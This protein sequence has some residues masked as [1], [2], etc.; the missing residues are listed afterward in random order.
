MP[1]DNNPKLPQLTL[2]WWMDGVTLPTAPEPQE[3]A[4]L[5]NGMQSFWQRVRGWFI[6]P[7]VQQDPLTCSLDM[8]N[9]KAWEC[10]ITRFRDEPLWLYR[11]R[12]AY[13]FINA[14]DAGSTQGFFKIMSRLGLRVV[15]IKERQE[16]LDW[17]RVSIEIDDTEI[18]TNQA[19]LAELIQSYGRTCRRY[20]H[21][22]SRV[23]VNSVAITEAC[24]DFQT[25]TITT[26]SSSEFAHYGSIAVPATEC[27]ND[28]QHLYV[29]RA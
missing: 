14:K 18:A 24:Q 12:V 29:R 22:S 20:D 28:Y 21:L 15:N 9:L 11:K 13:A 3:P 2:P 23:A 27:S 10:N 16:G 19:L 25:F 7:L 6:W 8:L 26:L 4:M 1:E 5:G 17:D